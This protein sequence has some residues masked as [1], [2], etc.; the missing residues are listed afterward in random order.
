MT[1]KPTVSAFCKSPGIPISGTGYVTGKINAVYGH[2]KGDSG[3]QELKTL[4]EKQLQLP[5]DYTATITLSG[6]RSMVDAMGGVEVEV[7]F[8][9]EYLPG[10]VLERGNSG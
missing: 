6:L 1:W 8:Q 7:P 5:I 2:P 10:M 4:V 3:I 9:M